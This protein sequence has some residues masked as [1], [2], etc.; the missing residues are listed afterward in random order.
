MGVVGRRRLPVGRRR[1]RG[2][3]GRAG[4]SGDRAADRH[5]RPRR[6][7]RAVRRQPRAAR[8]RR[9]ARAGVSMRTQVG[10]LLGSTGPAHLGYGIIAFIMV[11]LWGPAG[12]GLGQRVPHPPAA[13]RRPVGLP[14]VRRGGQGPRARP[15]RARRGGRGQGAAPH[16]PQHPGGR[17]ERVAWPSSSGCAPRRSPTPASPGCCTTS[18]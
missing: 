1:A 7:R 18:A 15:A 12:L 10:R 14:A 13:P 6:R 8:H 11:V 16:G 5:P 17:A 4:T 9:P 2:A 3:R